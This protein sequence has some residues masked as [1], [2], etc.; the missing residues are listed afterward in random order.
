[1]ATPILATKLYVPPPRPQAVRRQRLT[2]RLKQGL[3]DGRR[4][5][6]ISAPA[7]FGKT[8]LVAEWIAGVGRPV[9]W[10]SLDDG[11]NDPVRFLAYLVAAVQT[12]APK[13]GEEVVALLESQQPPPTEVILTAL[14]N[15]IAAQ[16]GPL[17]L[18]LDDY[19]VIEAQAVDQALNFLIE[20]LPPQLHV[21]ITSREDPPLPLARYRAR[22]QLTEVRAADLRFSAAEAAEFLSAVMGLALAA[23]DIAA[24]ETRTEG[25]IAGLQMAALSIQGQPDAHG[26]IQAFAGDHRY[27]VDYL[28]EEVL[29]RQ[30]D[31]LRRFL[32]QTAI[33]DRLN[34][35]LCDA[36]TG[37][38]GGSARLEALERGNVFVVPLDDRRQWYRYHHLFAD[39]LLAHLRAEQPDQI[40]GLHQR[41][42][43]W[44]E[45]QG[46][47][48]DAIRHALAAQD[49]ER[50]ASLVEPAVPDML[51]SRQEAALL[52]WLQALPDPVVRRRP[53]LSAGYASVL[54]SNGKFSGVE[55][56]LRDA[57]RWL[58]PP[59]GTRD[60]L[61]APAAPM[62]VVDEEAFRRLPG[63]VAVARAGH[64]L[65]RGDVEETVKYAQRALDLIPEDDHVR[66]GSAAALLGLAAWTNGDLEAAHQSYA[67]GM[68]SL[69]KA[70]H[71]SDVLGCSIAVADIRMAQGRLHEA[72]Q[73]YERALEMANP[74]GA[75]ALRGTGDMYVGLGELARERNDLP[76]ATQY[77][78]N[79]QALGEHKGLPQYPYRWRV[80]MAR[81]R[82]AAGDLDGALSLLEEAERRYTGDF[83]P[84]VRPVAAW[85]ARLWVAQ[86]RL[87]EALGWVRAQSL[88]TDDD[89]SYLREFQ[90]L[91]LARVLLAQYQ[92]DRTDGAL[93]EALRLLERLQQAAE[94]GGRMGSVIESLMLQALGHQAHGDLVSALAPLERALKLAEPAG[95]VRLFVDEGQP[96]ARLLRDAAASGRLPGFAGQ[97]LGA[98]ELESPPDR[99][100]ALHPAS[101][102]RQPLIE[103]LSQR[104]LEVLRLF[105]ADLS[106]PEIAEEL[107]IALSTL[108]THTKRIY[109][110][111]DVNNRRAAVTRATEL[112]LL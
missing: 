64:A 71:L 62:V 68:A 40:A 53:V 72:R 7:G 90:H 42:S 86:G 83:S 5:T 104:E 34:G 10:L 101:S 28:A 109:S 59:A 56:R 94:A 81:I 24:L 11:D 55:D 45:R 97:L 73:T 82:A 13:L 43:V 26:F 63:A 23:G 77:L 33:L 78:L 27:I 18:V 47:T 76:A 17:V 35:S 88:S 44:F 36:V 2:E 39:V 41:A 96:M 12:V 67:E 108:R 38:A 69:H 93:A 57:E 80:A 32:L 70:G 107:V 79:S 15:E 60:D 75:P 102:A 51:K 87:G 29:Q 66:H 1:M 46:S 65:A 106:G 111:L 89:L 105:K 3:A 48:A 14:L 21:V 98:I 37:Q 99:S 25:W 22:G 50:A 103:P 54:M 52:G 9:A 8:T 112:G 85:I 16:P 92:R 91:T 6:L 61:D 49:F 95:Y 4:L 100:D 19:H 74:P 84:N 31:P 20:H 30:P 110:K 58:E